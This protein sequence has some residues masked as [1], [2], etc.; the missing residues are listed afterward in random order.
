MWTAEF[1]EGVE[2]FLSFSLSSRSSAVI[3]VQYLITSRLFLKHT[4]LYVLRSFWGLDVIAGLTLVTLPKDLIVF[5]GD[6]KTQYYRCAEYSAGMFLVWN[7]SEKVCTADFI[8]GKK[9]AVAWRVDGHVLSFRWHRGAYSQNAEYLK[10]SCLFSVQVQHWETFARLST[11]RC[12]LVRYGVLPRGRAKESII[13]KLGHYER[14]I[15][16]RSL[17]IRDDAQ[18][19]SD[20]CGGQHSQESR[21][22]FNLHTTWLVLCMELLGKKKN[23]YLQGFPLPTSMPWEFILVSAGCVLSIRCSDV[24]KTM[25]WQKKKWR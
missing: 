25:Q 13:N 9:V 16:S 8:S 20:T 12:C 5:L 23:N 11:N 19:C 24:T 21:S 18:H 10:V 2:V 7:L 14:I 6:W 15:E 22:A 3:R 1:L 4:V 17:L